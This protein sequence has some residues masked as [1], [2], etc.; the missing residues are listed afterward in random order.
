MLHK[1][2]FWVLLA[3]LLAFALRALS[4]GVQSLWND[5]GISVALAPLD[6]GS[7]A[8]SAARDIQPPLYYYLLHFWVPL[9]GQTEYAVRFLSLIAGVLTVLVTYRIASHFFDRQTALLASALTAWSP[10]QVYYSQ[11]ARMYMWVTLFS[12]ASVLAMTLMLKRGAVVESAPPTRKTETEP[13][14]PS[15][16][17]AAARLAAR[18]QRTLAWLVYIGATIAALYT[19]YFAASVLAAENLAFLAW[20]YLGWRDRRGNIRHSGVFWLAAQ[21]VITIVVA[22]WYLYVRDQLAS[23]PAISE[24]LD[25]P[26]LVARLTGVFA[27]GITL[28]GPLTAAGAAALALLC[29]IGLRRGRSTQADW[30]IV[31]LA[32]WAVV[33]V[34]AMYIVSITRPAYN[35]K[36]LLLATP[37]VYILGARG[38]AWLLPRPARPLFR[39]PALVRVV[40]LVVLG[41]ALLAPAALSLNNN[42]FDPQFARDDYRS[43]LHIIDEQERPGDGILV[44]A[45]GQ[46]DVVKYYHRGAQPLFLLPKM[47]PPRPRVTREDVD[48]M[49]GQVERLFAVYYGTEQSDPQAIVETRLAERAF[50]AADEWHGNVRL[51]VYGIAPAARGPVQPVGVKVGSEI[52]LTSYQLDEH[53]VHPGD[54]L[55]LTL[56][57]HADRAPAGRYKVFV[58]LINADDQ[59][60]AQRDG[61][62]VGDTRITTTWK[63][64]DTVVDNY[65]I[66]VPNDRPGEFRI[67]V[68]MYRVDDGARLPMVTPDGQPAGDHLVIASVSAR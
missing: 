49:V 8:Q 22:P 35:P 44:N 47:R 51:A 60:V 53:L 16:E 48:A 10:F 39:A 67:E 26:T 15:R 21:I 32:L 34:A 25:L 24:P 9:T 17:P 65:G 63:A 30:G 6:L 52:T 56:N 46:V 7:I 3:V 68:G 37:A 41:F 40:A 12:A 4:L 18:R 29:V 33:P 13:G 19:Q 2:R 20:L 27:V 43:I 5:E 54:V 59:V 14:G 42:Y 28:D 36:L 1:N 11:E 57:W 66:L 58:H 31:T 50:K 23:W 64:G 45:P 38:L 61:E 55:T 62:P